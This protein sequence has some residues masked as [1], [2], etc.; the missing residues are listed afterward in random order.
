MRVLVV[1]PA[2]GGSKGIPRK[3]LRKL[4]ELPLI[5][6]A[7]R[8]AKA[9]AFNTDV[10]VSS[11]DDEILSIANQLGANCHKRSEELANDQTT[12]DPVIYEAFQFAK[13][14]KGVSYDLIATL[15]P[16]SPLL[17]RS[18]LEGALDILQK[19]TSIHTIISAV[20][21]THLSWSKVDDKYVPNY[22]K[23]L[24]RQE[25]T[26]NY[27]ET[28]GFLITRASV[29]SLNNRIGDNVSLYPL[30]GKES[31]DIDT[32][33][34]WNICEY[35]LRRKNILFVV[36]GNKTVGL[37]HVY[38]TLVLANEILSHDVTFL[39]DI[40]SKLA[41]NKIKESNYNVLIQEEES[42]VDDI[43]KISPDVVIND[44]LD[45]RADYVEKLKQNN[46]QV[47]NIEDLGEGAKF[48]DLVINAIYPEQRK[49][50][51]HYYGPD[52]FCARDEFLLLPEK[53][54]TDNV[55]KVLI[56]FGG[57]DPSNLTKK[58]LESIYTYC[59]EQRIK[60]TVILGLGYDKYYSLPDYSDVEIKKDV[61][62]IALEMYNADIC[63]TSAG[64]TTYELALVGTPSIVLAQNQ[65]ELT[66]FFADEANGFISLGLGEGVSKHDIE[67]SFISLVND[68][69]QRR[70]MFN[71]MKNNNIHRGKNKV[72]QLIKRQ[73]E[74]EDK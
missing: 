27:K 43:L 38:N 23:R 1:I 28:G 54:I 66:H 13:K 69:S 44:I 34:D 74:N 11:E 61:K 49:Q 73:I 60:I 62:N 21:D 26:P 17:E 42:I 31:I 53:I 14:D 4:G 67:S 52:Y 25:L 35:Y 45:T 71:K 10:Y 22:E 70:F 30:S 63:F 40:D 15:Q 56:T 55:K 58:T 36:T 3:N 20:N 16:T 64:R 7:I 47:I 9:L 8:N 59:S 39:V 5:A 37:G 24:N 33:E 41:Y 65:R 18:S 32:F 57:V 6:Y 19:N 72:I 68:G 29:I 48:A 2:R 50:L 51:N 46:F 12:L